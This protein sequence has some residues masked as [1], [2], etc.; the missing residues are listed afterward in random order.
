MHLGGLRPSHPH[1]VAR[2]RWCSPQVVRVAVPAAVPGSTCASTR[3]YLWQY[4]RQYPGLCG[5]TRGSTQAV[6]NR[7]PCRARCSKAT[8]ARRP[9]STSSAAPATIL[10]SAGL[11]CSRDE[12]P[13]QRDLTKAG[14]STSS[15]SC[16]RCGE[17]RAEIGVGAPAP[18]RDPDPK[19]FHREVTS[20]AAERLCSCTIRC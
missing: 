19:P 8:V 16:T 18:T 20:G 2:V 9:F 15:G 11:S 7:S 12:L 14:L 6:A 17:C 4:P 10:G 5:S 1:P 13:L 3:Q